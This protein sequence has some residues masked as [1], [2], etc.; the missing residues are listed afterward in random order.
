MISLYNVNKPVDTLSN[1]KSLT[2]LRFEL[3]FGSLTFL[4]QLLS[5][6]PSIT[7]LTLERVSLEYGSE[8][9]VDLNDPKLYSSLSRLRTIEITHDLGTSRSP[10][11]HQFLFHSPVSL[12]LT[13]LQYC[14]YIDD[15]K[16]PSISNFLRTSGSSLQELKLAAYFVTCIDFDLGL[17]SCHSIRTLE[18]T[19]ISRTNFAQVNRALLR[20]GSPLLWRL[21][22]KFDASFMTPTDMISSKP[23]WGIL[24]TTLQK[25]SPKGLKE[26]A[27]DIHRGVKISDLLPRT[28]ISR[29]LRREIIPE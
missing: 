28:S 18:I 21:A 29:I 1:L 22:F 25:Q 9:A 23:D 17:Q 12:N 27:I 15:V 20:L 11:L 14:G 10:T 13:R 3:T 16:Y 8:N 19:G 5:T 7:R 4:S 6:L 2:H 26:V 24:D